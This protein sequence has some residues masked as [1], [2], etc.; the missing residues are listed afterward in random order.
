MRR[1][2]VQFNST[3]AGGDLGDGSAGDRFGANR[4]DDT[5]HGDGSE[6]HGS[7]RRDMDGVG[8]RRIGG[9][10]QQR[11]GSGGDVYRSRDCA[12]PRDRDGD[13]HLG[14]GWNKGSVGDDN[15]YDDLDGRPS[16]GNRDAEGG[17][18]NRGAII[19]FDRDGGK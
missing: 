14:N 11:L 6:R 8:R 18:G 2:W 3:S 19:R 4:S 9:P 1:R 5:A 15:G 10:D 17:R 7:Q 16:G 12:K 13:G